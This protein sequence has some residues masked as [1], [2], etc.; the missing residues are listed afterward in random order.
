M[1][2]SLPVE[3]AQFISDLDIS[4]DV[5]DESSYCLVP[6]VRLWYW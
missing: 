5:N 2:A 6:P 3:Q 1:E 4:L